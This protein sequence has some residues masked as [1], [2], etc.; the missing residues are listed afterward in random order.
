MNKRTKYGIPSS[1]ITELEKGKIL[2][3]FKTIEKCSWGECKGVF[4]SFANNYKGRIN[5]MF[6]LNKEEYKKGRELFISCILGII[7][8]IEK[9]SEVFIGIPEKDC[10]TDN[11]LRETNLKTKTIITYQIQNTTFDAKNK[12]S[13]SLKDEIFKKCK[14]YGTPKIKSG[15]L[16]IHIR[17]NVLGKEVK[18]LFKDLEKEKENIPFKQIIFIGPATGEKNIMNLIIISMESVCDMRMLK[19]NYE[20]LKIIKRVLIAT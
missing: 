5:E 3:K 20:T 14:K 15:I 8:S 19:F 6:S 10:G 1:V 2:Y 9:E 11:Y 16:F 12:N 7:I 17:S 4:D 13:K 18:L